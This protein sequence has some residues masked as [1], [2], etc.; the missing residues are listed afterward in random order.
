MPEATWSQL[1]IDSLHLVELADIASGDYGVQV[2]GQDLE[3]L[4]SVGA[5][6]D[7]IWSQAQ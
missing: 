2:Q 3:E 5:A 4:G 1:G 6:I 7:L